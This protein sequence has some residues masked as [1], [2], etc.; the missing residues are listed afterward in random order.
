MNNH[1]M[2]IPAGPSGLAA[3]LALK[4]ALLVVAL[5]WA[6]PSGAQSAFK[7]GYLS[8]EEAI[9]SMP[10]YPVVRQNLDTLRRQYEDEIRRS[11][12]EFNEKYEAFLD[13][14][15]NH[16]HMRSAT[17]MAREIK[18][19]IFQ[20][21]GLTASAG[22]SYNK[23]LAKIASDQNKPDGLFVI[24]PRQAEDFLDKLPVERFFGVGHVTA[25]KMHRMGIRTGHDLKLRSEAELVRAF[26]KA[27]HYYYI[28][29]RGVDDR[30]VEPNRIRKSMG[31]ENTFPA[32]MDTYEEL[33]RVLKETC[34][35]VVAR[36]K[37]HAFLEGRT[38]TLKVKY[39][40]FRTV[41]RSKTMPFPVVDADTLYRTGVELLRGVDVSP[42][43]RLLGISVKKPDQMGWKG[44][45]VQLEIEFEE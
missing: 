15:V 40:D 5:M 28:N 31:A 22:V 41:S 3:K 14:T 39:A 7:F 16:K 10:D 24:E 32:D 29:A 1:P 26:G 42:K 4:A 17:L 13:V 2:P 27:G 33:D 8:Y 34:E 37:R 23:F 35:E 30:P 19:R 36:L 43:V 9:R 21:T 12:E 45:G 38:V 18:Q 20:A 6:L 25:D 44:D 11:E